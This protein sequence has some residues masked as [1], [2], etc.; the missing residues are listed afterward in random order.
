MLR[1]FVQL[2]FDNTSVDYDWDIVKERVLL[3][4]GVSFSLETGDTIAQ[5]N[6][7]EFEQVRPI[8]PPDSGT[9]LGP[10]DLFFGGLLTFSRDVGEKTWL[11]SE[12]NDL[13]FAAAGCPGRL[14]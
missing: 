9:Y 14:W 11:P 13:S 2:G 5:G 4:D 1:T 12:T 7:V 3:P 8:S 6:Q 10:P